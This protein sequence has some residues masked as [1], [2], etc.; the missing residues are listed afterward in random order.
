MSAL[1]EAGLLH[2]FNQQNRLAQ[3]LNQ[4]ALAN[5]Y[6][7]SLL[8]PAISE[9]N[10]TLPMFHVPYMSSP[11]QGASAA[12]QLAQ[13]MVNST[14]TAGLQQGMS[15]SNNNHNNNSSAYQN[16][17][18][19]NS[20]QSLEEQIQIHQSQTMMLE[21]MAAYRKMV[22]DKAFASLYAPFFETNKH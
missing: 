10:P 12:Q 19:H 7:N 20:P 3:T 1:T 21:S 5:H 2:H 13:S 11:F 18:H 16:G 8:S 6:G 15:M 14:N 4:Q 9:Y 17:G 22:G